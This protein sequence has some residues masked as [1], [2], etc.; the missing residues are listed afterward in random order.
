MNCLHPN[1]APS[2]TATILDEIGMRQRGTTEAYFMYAARRD[3]AGESGIAKS[4]SSYLRIKR[5][6]THT[7]CIFP[8]MPTTVPPSG[9]FLVTTAPAPTRTP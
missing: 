8:G 9:T 5:V 6:V 2:V 1:E 3:E 7:P 4:V